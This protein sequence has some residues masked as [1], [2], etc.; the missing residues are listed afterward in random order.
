MTLLERDKQAM[1]RASLR[2]EGKIHL[3]LVYANEPGMQT[4][5]LQLEGAL[6]FRLLLAQWLGD[7]ADWLRTSTPF[8]YLVARDSL[9]SS[10]ELEVHYASLSQHYLQRLRED[11]RLDYLG[12]RPEQLCTPIPEDQL[13]RHYNLEQ[14]CAGYTT[15]ELAVCTELLAAHLR[16]AITTDSRIRFRGDS[17]VKSAERGL[18]GFTVE[19]WSARGSWKEYGDQ[20]VNA[21]WDG[22]P[23]IDHTMGMGYQEGLL[24]RLK[25]RVIAQAP[26]S[27]RKANSLTIVLG[28]YGDVVFRHDGS[29][30]LSW[31]PLAMN[32]WSHDLQPPE[33]WMAPCQGIISKAEF[34]RISQ[35]VCN[36]LDEWIPGIARAQVL[37]VDA[38]IIVA[39]GD[40]DVDDRASALH[41]RTRVGVTSIDGYH[42]LDAGKLTTAPL[43]ANEA[44]DNVC[45]A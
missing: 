27:L 26:E 37:Q 32:G 22:R 31:Y 6:S 14:V 18:N 25:Y 42:S 30:Y 34:E 17:T 5:R 10:A 24:H 13:R 36:A 1:N 11:N 45:N 2:N 19:G 7:A 35:G 41:N 29:A 40:S 4:A 23:A 15:A 39:F 28:P 44:A 9:L 43:F 21:A 33:E 16:A 8:D 3:G 12:T 20:V 38:G